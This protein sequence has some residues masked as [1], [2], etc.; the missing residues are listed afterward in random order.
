MD[1]REE[2]TWT[3]EG[4]TALSDIRARRSLMSSSSNFKS[5]ETHLSGSVFIHCRTFA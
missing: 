2:A 3:L 1:L 5:P 4:A